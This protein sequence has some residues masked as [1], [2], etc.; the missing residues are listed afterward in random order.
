MIKLF[1]RHKDKEE[2]DKYYITYKY[3]KDTKWYVNAYKVY[4][5][6]Q[7]H[8]VIEK[9]V[10]HEYIDLYTKADIINA[11]EN[12]DYKDEYKYKLQQL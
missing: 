1:C 6:N 9:R 5:C 8:R 7:C 3:D 12:K 2:I 11:L 10:L 4:K